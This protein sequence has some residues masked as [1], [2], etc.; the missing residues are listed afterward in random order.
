MPDVYIISLSAPL[1]RRTRCG[2]SP[3]YT[4]RSPKVTV[5]LIVL[6]A[7]YAPSGVADVTL[8]TAGPVVLTT[9]ALEYASE[10]GSP[11]AGSVRLAVFP[12][13]STMLPVRAVSL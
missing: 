9:M 11:G 7:P 5:M 1:M 13:R 10:P 3:L 4:T 2:R 12:A 6:P 8:A